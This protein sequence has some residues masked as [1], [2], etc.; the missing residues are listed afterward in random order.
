MLFLMVFLYFFMFLLS[1]LIYNKSTIFTTSSS[2]SL[3]MRLDHSNI[4]SPEIAGNGSNKKQT[5]Q[6]INHKERNKAFETGHWLE[7]ARKKK[8]TK[9][10]TTKKLLHKPQ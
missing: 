2:S 5:Q 6:E 10:S 7:A 4:T 9:V 8:R 1:K 3:E